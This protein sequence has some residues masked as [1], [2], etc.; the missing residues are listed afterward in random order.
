MSFQSIIARLITSLLL[1]PCFSYFSL[2]ENAICFAV[3]IVNMWKIVSNNTSLIAVRLKNHLFNDALW[4]SILK[5]RCAHVLL[6][7]WHFNNPFWCWLLSC[8]WCCSWST[9]HWNYLFVSHKKIK[10]EKILLKLPTNG[11]CKRHAQQWIDVPP[12]ARRILNWFLSKLMMP[13]IFD[14]HYSREFWKSWPICGMTSISWK[15]TIMLLT[16]F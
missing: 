15:S 13:L 11:C 1:C 10:I 7:G 14:V 5:S 6:I 4:Y 8:L 12:K 2:T 3:W 9:A 16:I